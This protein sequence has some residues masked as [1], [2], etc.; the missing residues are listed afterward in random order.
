M[1][2]APQRHVKGT[3]GIQHNSYSESVNIDMHIVLH[4]S[5]TYLLSELVKEQPG[6]LN[7]AKVV[8]ANLQLKVIL[9]YVLCASHYASIQDQKVNSF[10]KIQGF[11]QCLYTAQICKI[12]LL[13]LHVTL[14]ARW[15]DQ[16]DLGVTECDATYLEPCIIEVFSNFMTSFKVSRCD[17]HPG[18]SQAQGSCGLSSNSRITT[19]HQQTILR[20]L[21]T[22]AHA[23]ARTCYDSCL[24]SQVSALQSL[25]GGCA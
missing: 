20:T 1:T 12:Q 14:H 15:H 23:C 16:K 19:C 4:R 25:Y 2:T 6:Q 21:K 18:S 11:P 24:A 8:C 22:S 10:L 9:G 5:E 3:S 7:M 17:D 13:H